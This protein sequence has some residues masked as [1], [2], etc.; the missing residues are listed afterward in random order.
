MQ[1]NP[2]TCFYTK[3]TYYYTQDEIQAG[4]GCAAKEIWYKLACGGDFWIFD[5]MPENS[6][7]YR[8]CPCCGGVLVETDD[9][10]WEDEEPFTLA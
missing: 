2:K 4:H 1:Q 9:D 8:Y 10:V 6:K 7:D 3:R 5:W